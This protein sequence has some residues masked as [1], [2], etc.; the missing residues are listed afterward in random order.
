LILRNNS[1]QIQNYRL[2]ASG[3]NLEFSPPRTEVA[4]A[5][6]AERSVSLR[7]FPK[8]GVAGVC[9]WRLHVTGGASVDLRFRAIVL[10]REGT[11]VWT[12]DL[13]GDGSPEWVIE[14]PKVRAVFSSKDGGRWTEFV[15]KDTNTNFLPAEGALASTGPVQVQA[16]GGVLFFAGNGW[17][18]SVSLAADSLTLEQTPTLPAESL[19]GHTIGNLSFSIERQSATQMT[20]RMRQAT[21]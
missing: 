2:E 21:P 10:P 14:S 12:A 3:D 8:E 19:T 7:V 6:L 11:A 16:E 20:Y 15:W 9:D 13:D 5:A 18:R 17:S 4:V 1:A